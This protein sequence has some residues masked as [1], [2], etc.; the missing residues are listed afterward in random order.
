MQTLKRKSMKLMIR[1]VLILVVGI[2]T[3]SYQLRSQDRIVDIV[4]TL[5]F[6]SERSSIIYNLSYGVGTNY[7]DTTEREYEESV[8][9]FLPPGGYLI[10]FERECTPSDGD[11]PCYWKQD[12]RGIPDSVGDQ[13]RTQF[14]LKYNIHIHNQTG[15]GFQLSILNSDWPVGVDSVNIVDPDV[16]TAFNETFTGPAIVT[17]EDEFTARLAVTAY[18]NL[19][20]LSVMDFIQGTSEK[21]L[22]IGPNPSF[23]ETTVV[24]EMRPGDRI[25]VMNLMGETV[26][27]REITE[28][29]NRFVL[30]IE[31]LTEGMYIVAYKDANGLL[32]AQSKMQIIR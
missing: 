18:Y 29:T 31:G 3:T 32:T 30:P 23:R 21:Q 2:I 6:S 27:S 20:T 19:A 8:P 12:L 17:I 26:L 13:L 22:H 16:P 25:I 4:G 11:P 7:T 10:V 15:A 14:A 5:R 1:S 9:P 28:S 24:T